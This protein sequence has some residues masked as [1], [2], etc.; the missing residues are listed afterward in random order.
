MAA[1]FT[2]E[3]RVA[4]YGY[5]NCASESDDTLVDYRDEPIIEGAEQ[6]IT[7]ETDNFCVPVVA[8]ETSDLTDSKFSE[9]SVETRTTCETNLSSQVKEESI[10][11][12]AT[13]NSSLLG[14]S[15]YRNTSIARSTL[16]K[17]SIDAP[18]NASGAWVNED[19]ALRFKRILH[20]QRKEGIVELD[21]ECVAYGLREPGQPHVPTV[22][23]KDGKLHQCHIGE[24]VAFRVLRP[25]EFESRIWPSGAVAMADTMMPYTSTSAKPKNT[26]L[27][28]LTR[29]GFTWNKS[30][31]SQYPTCYR[32]SREV[33]DRQRDKLSPARGKAKKARC[34]EQLNDA[35]GHE[36]PFHPRITAATPLPFDMPIWASIWAAAADMGI[37]K[38]SL[39]PSG[40]AA[41]LELEIIRVPPTRK[42]SLGRSQ[43]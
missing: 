25:I 38:G 23:D 7:S 20:L 6:Y 24:I 29:R 27:G 33:A 37:T 42:L 30:T 21:C 26:F 43:T 1:N 3:S 22:S 28:Q 41:F 31:A 18:D 4:F 17:R 14:H 15:P 39:S 19:S 11:N 34:G 16:T 2:A 36:P 10:E 12:V 32:W 9:G 13:D 5:I 40:S 35:L 8:P